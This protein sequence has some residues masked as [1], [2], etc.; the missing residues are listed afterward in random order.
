M[1]NRF[2]LLFFGALLGMAFAS[3]LPVS[4]ADALTFPD[5]Y[6]SIIKRSVKVYWADFPFWR[7]WKAQLWQ[8]SRLDPDA[9]SP[10]GASGLAQFMP[11][12]WREIAPA[13]GYAHLPPTSV[14]PAINAGAYYMAKLRRAW[15]APRPQD[16][17][18]WLAAA[19]YNAGFGNIL[20]AQKVCGGAALYLEIIACLP[21]VTGAHSTETITYVERIKRWW[22]LMEARL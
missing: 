16:D 18:H 20:K 21:G 13:L 11:G 8:E 2:R 9:M 4:S 17:R 6:D 3:S 5:K 1:N 19:S 14:R 15:S 12:T 22:G 7:A 10:V